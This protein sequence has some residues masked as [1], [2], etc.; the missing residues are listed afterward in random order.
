MLLFRPLFRPAPLFSKSA[1]TARRFFSLI[2]DMETVNTTERLARLRELMKQTDNAVDVYIV[3]SEDQHA[4]EYIAECDERR[5]FISGFDG[6]A[7]C[8]IVTAKEALLFTDGRY[9]LQAEKQLDKNWTLMKYGTP[10]VPTWQVYLAQNLEKS[11][12]IGLDAKLISAEDAASLVKSLEPRGSSLVPLKSNIV[13]S[14]WGDARPSRPANKVFHLPEKY[15]GESHVSKLAR[16]RAE[17]TKAKAKS[18]VVT[19]LDEIAWLFNFRGSDI[20]YNPVFFSYATIT[21]DE[22]VLFLQNPDTSIITA[23]GQDVKTMEYEEIWGYLKKLAEGIT[24]E[25]EEKIL[26]TDKS[27]MAITHAIGEGK[28]SIKH[29]P[30]SSL[31]SIK[32]AVELEGFRQCHIRD[33]VALTRYFAWL[34]EQLNAG[35]VLSEWQAAEQLEKFRSELADFKGLSFDTISSTGPNGA[36]IHYSP[37][38]T[39]SAIIKK[40]QVYLCDSGAQFLDGTTDVTRT[41]HFGTPSAEEKRAFTRVLQGH[42]ALDTLVFPN[43]TTGLLIDAIA[44][45]PLWQDGLDY[46]HGTG[47]GLGHFLNVHEGPHSISFRITSNNHPIKAGM[48][49]SNEPGYYADGRF[50]IRIESVVLVREAQTPNN[51]ADK[52]Y[53]RLE[54]VTMCPIQT[55]FIQ[56]DLLTV[57]EVKWLN[58]YHVEVW[59]KVSP[60]LKHDTRAL[61]WLKRECE[62]I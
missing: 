1:S 27:S 25:S 8:A 16:L 51:F 42:I 21:M 57:D 22:A 26:V 62:A 13:D 17:L 34:E 30:I 40:D 31:K 28:Y 29:S 46:R 12:K 54:N 59:D 14:V 9:Y 23:L 20:A 5:A 3:P 43:G 52:G 55:S 33:G 39:D 15:S 37:S 2:H 56:K 36:I 7:G 58:A 24:A 50:G 32:N 44:R 45:R 60:L 10:G 19:S 4:S 11:S 49:I 48:T 47:H 35:E 53:L 18:M 61:E 41:W 6:S 38:P